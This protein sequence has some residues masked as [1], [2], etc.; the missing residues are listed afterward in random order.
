VVGLGYTIECEVNEFDLKTLPYREE[1]PSIFS[2]FFQGVPFI[3][4]GH[5]SFPVCITVTH[6]QIRL[7]YMGFWPSAR[8]LQNCFQCYA[9]VICVW[10]SLLALL[11]T[12]FFKGVV[13]T[14]ILNQGMNSHIPKCTFQIPCRSRCT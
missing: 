12:A 9:I 14:C 11:G 5:D 3:R 13:H 1:V 10:H 2:V 6:L 8:Y 4:T 7:G